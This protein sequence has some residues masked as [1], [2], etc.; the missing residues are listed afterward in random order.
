MVAVGIVIGVPVQAILLIYEEK[1]RRKK[2]NIK[3]TE[4]EKA[5]LERGE[6]IIATFSFKSSIIIGT[7]LTVIS[8]LLLISTFL[9]YL[10]ELMVSNFIRVI[11]VL[12]SLTG[13]ATLGW[14]ILRSGL[15]RLILPEIREFSLTN[16]R[17]LIW[18]GN[19][20]KI[21]R[22][23]KFKPG[24]FTL[25]HKGFYIRGEE[26]SGEHVSMS[27]PINKSDNQDFIKVLRNLEILVSP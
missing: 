13:M 15:R 1:I 19:V 18:N 16:E 27:I 23:T 24:L 14:F 11:G 10:P 22:V 9:L 7:V 8:F 26:Y 4:R 25:Q 17:R 2:R 21:E 3:K 20:I 6:T 5:E 12:G